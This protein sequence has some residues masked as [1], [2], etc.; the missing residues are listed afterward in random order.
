MLR[1]LRASMMLTVIAVL[2]FTAIDMFA[3]TGFGR[4]VYSI[5]GMLLIFCV[6][7]VIAPLVLRKFPL[8]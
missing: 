4:H 7:F 1:R 3:D 8:R 2:I 5:P 6:A